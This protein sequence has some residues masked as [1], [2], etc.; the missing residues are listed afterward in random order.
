MKEKFSKTEA[1]P[2]RIKYSPKHIAGTEVVEA[3]NTVFGTNS[4]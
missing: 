2:M 3:L 1:Q 4:R